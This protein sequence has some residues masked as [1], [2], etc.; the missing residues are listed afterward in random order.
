MRVLLLLAAALALAGVAAAAGGGGGG[1]RSVLGIGKN[2]RT[3]L[4]DRKFAASYVRA[5]NF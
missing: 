1:M 5:C 4:Q 3:L 2:S